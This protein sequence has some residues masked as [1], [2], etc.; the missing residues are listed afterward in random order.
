MQPVSI[1]CH[2][3]RTRVVLKGA[4]DVGAAAAAYGTLDQALSRGLPLQLQAGELERTDAGGL[5]LLLLFV[6]SARRRGVALTWRTVSPSLMNDAEL[7][8]LGS[9]LE[10]PR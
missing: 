6:H 9:A 8:G 4:L 3:D 7:L 5:Q 10:L 2:K 1:T